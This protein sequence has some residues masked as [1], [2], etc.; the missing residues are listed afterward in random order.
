VLQFNA[1]GDLLLRQTY[2]IFRVAGEVASMADEGV[3]TVGQ[4]AHRQ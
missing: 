1:V 2:Y 3:S 4:K